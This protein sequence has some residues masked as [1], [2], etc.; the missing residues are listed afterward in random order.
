MLPRFSRPPYLLTCPVLSVFN[1]IYEPLLSKVSS[2]S[3]ISHHAMRT[4]HYTSHMP[5]PINERL[6]HTSPPINDG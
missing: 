5:L 1:L 3:A 2:D 4:S 6:T